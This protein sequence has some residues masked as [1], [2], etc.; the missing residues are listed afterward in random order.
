MSAWLGKPEQ[1]FTRNLVSCQNKPM[2]PD[3]W[4]KDA[5]FYQVYLRAFQ[6]SDGGPGVDGGEGDPFAGPAFHGRPPRRGADRPAS[7]PTS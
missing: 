5:I 2:N 3:L 7:K 1:I 6:D 4:Y